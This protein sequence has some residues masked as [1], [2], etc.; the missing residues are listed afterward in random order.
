MK[1]RIGSV[2]YSDVVITPGDYSWE[3][4]INR[5]LKPM[6]L[7]ERMA[8]LHSNWYRE[9]NDPEIFMFYLNLAHGYGDHVEYQATG[10]IVDSW[11]NGKRIQ[12][13]MAEYMLRAK[14]F[15]ILANNFF[16]IPEASCNP[17]YPVLS[18]Y[19]N[20][21]FTALVSFFEPYD[22]IGGF[23]NLRPKYTS[24]LGKDGGQHYI[25]TT[26][27]FAKRFASKALV[28]LCRK[29]PFPYSSVEPIDLDIA[30][31][32]RFP[33]LRIATRLGIFNDTF[34]LIRENISEPVFIFFF[35]FLFQ[36]CRETVT[37]SSKPG[38]VFR[39]KKVEYALRRCVEKRHP[40]ALALN[41]LFITHRPSI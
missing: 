22:G 28:M 27:A 25:E 36:E 8:W 19:R 17:N 6:S 1:K 33:I 20:P 11:Y 15:T 23:D 24:N 35:E 39:D 40:F 7:Q 34:N 16:N 4:R 41:N 9:G 2:D 13:N 21:L 38:E 5:W 12:D 29:N 26:N 18:P 10:N 30:W 14:A 31:D 37:I 3:A 32:C